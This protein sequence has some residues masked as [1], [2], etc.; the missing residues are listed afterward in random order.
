MSKIAQTARV[1]PSTKIADSAEIRGMAEIGRDVVIGSR[2]KIGNNT[3]IGEGSVIGE[4]VTVGPYVK[5]GLGVLIMDGAKI[6]PSF[7][8]SGSKNARELLNGVTIGNGVFLHNEVEIGQGAIIP[9][10]RTIACLGNFGSKNRVV[11]VYGSDK[12]PLYS[13]GCQIGVPYEH[14]EDHVAR[15]TFTVQS[16]A[17]TYRPFLHIFA[18]VGEVVQEAYNGEAQTVQML[19][20]RRDEIGMYAYEPAW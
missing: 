11:T 7:V 3:I 14:F 4:N 9:T 10:Q 5:L 16:S 1:Y 8:R 2:S 19:K 18:S 13:I 17:D 15:A 12:G 6:C 20:V